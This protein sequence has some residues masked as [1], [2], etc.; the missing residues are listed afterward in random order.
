MVAARRLAAAARERRVIRRLEARGL[1][2][3]GDA[4]V[5]LHGQTIGGAWRIDALYAVGA[6]G[7]VFTTT[8]LADASAPSAV[9]KIPLLPYHRPADLSSS[10]LRHRRAALREE[11]RNLERSGSRFM[12]KS[13]GLHEFRNPLLDRH[14][15]GPFGEPDPA[16]VM[17]RLPGLDVDLWLARIHRSGIEKTVLHE[18]LDG[19]AIV[20]LD[21]LRDL[22]ER[23]FFYADLRPGN[24]RVIGGPLRRVRLL[25]AG[26]LVEVGDETGRF[27][28][29]PH[30][31][32]PALFEK[33]YVGGAPIV[34]SAEVQA[35]MAGRT[36]YEIATGVVPV[37]GRPL[38][39][40]A[41]KECGVSVVVADVIDGLGTGSFTSVIPAI[42]YLGRHAAQRHAARQAAAAI[43]PSTKSE[44]VR[45][46]SAPSP[47]AIAPPVV[48]ASPPVPESVASM[49]A[50][51]APA[52]V[53][54]P[55]VVPVAAAAPAPVA[56]AP[57]A[58]SPAAAP[59]G[60]WR[61]LA[62]RAAVWRRRRHD[63]L[64]VR[65]S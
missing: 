44:P 58:Q 6:E 4:L 45:P 46:A 62:D 53:F 33:R 22:H 49:S 17:E 3:L 65:P 31:L 52:L 20:L 2:G 64:G 1:P 37:P 19:I 29:V 51:T 13:C 9:V 7:A 36:L 40:A 12:P 63:G 54:E 43:H 55:V 27:P 50:G 24:L 10:L 60:F 15:G 42:R 59:R 14:R 18:H 21:A 16:L 39:A 48:V 56:A 5:R 38:D 8:N 28:H 41:L 47:A 61:R 23:G 32:P 25:D 30:Y 57:R 34:P 11:A 35:E 26:S